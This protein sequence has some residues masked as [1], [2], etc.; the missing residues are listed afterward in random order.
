MPHDTAVAN[1][2]RRMAPLEENLA[3]LA[4]DLAAL[5]SDLVADGRVVRGLMV[6]EETLTLRHT[7]FRRV[8]GES[9]SPSRALETKARGENHST[10]NAGHSLARYM[11]MDQIDGL[12]QV[13]DTLLLVTYY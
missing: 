9:V 2:P 6:P 8:Q 10:G 5:A 7:A 12:A 11:D 4:D 3:A 13:H 1:S